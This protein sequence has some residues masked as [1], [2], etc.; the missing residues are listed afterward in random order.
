MKLMSKV[1]LLRGKLPS[2]SMA[3]ILYHSF[4]GNSLICNH[5]NKQCWKDSS[6]PYYL[7]LMCHMIFC[8]TSIC[9]AEDIIPLVNLANQIATF[10]TDVCSKEL[11]SITRSKSETGNNCYNKY[12]YCHC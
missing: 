7:T 11:Q 5:S 6:N 4:E 2:D 8:H 12:C 9:D 1:E 3:T 10:A